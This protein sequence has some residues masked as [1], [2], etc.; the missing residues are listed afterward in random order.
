MKVVLGE[1]PGEGR[2]VPDRRGHH[3]SY[4]T[5]GPGNIFQIDLFSISGILKYVGFEKIKGVKRAKSPW[6]LIC[7]DMYSR[8]V[9]TQYVGLSSKMPDIIEALEKIFMKMGNPIIIQ[10]DDEFNT[11]LFREFCR[12]RNIR[13]YFWKPHELPK[14]QLV[15]RAIKTI[16][17][18]ML[19]YIDIYGWPTSGDLESDCQQVLDACTWYYNRV[20]HL[21]IN[22]I[23]FEVFN[24]FDLNRQKT[25]IIKYPKIKAGTIV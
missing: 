15:E 10:A 22:A 11:N 18:L 25:K 12:D 7:I 9:E 2:G 21:G 19:K 4:W 14:N 5:Y 24:G 23:P 3:I 20:W 1:D 16:K 6:I 17:N 13:M 8:Y